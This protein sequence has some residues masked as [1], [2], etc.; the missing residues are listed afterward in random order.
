M[1]KTNQSRRD[2]LKSSALAGTIVAGS[3]LSSCE[4]KSDQ[5]HAVKYE[6][7]AQFKSQ[8][9]QPAEGYN[10][11][12]FSQIGYEQGMPVKVMVR[13]PKK[14]LLSENATCQLIPTGGEQPYQSSFK[15]W[16]DLWKSHWWIAEFDSI[17]ESGEWNVLAKD[18]GKDFANN[19][20]LLHLQTTYTMQKAVLTS[21]AL[22]QRSRVL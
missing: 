18:S 22:K 7:T 21:R 1:K 13:L 6:Q 17:D 4:N 8:N 3:A 15:Y 10:G 11:L 5:T 16:G 9:Y 12:L 20:Q 19:D 14:E 2:F